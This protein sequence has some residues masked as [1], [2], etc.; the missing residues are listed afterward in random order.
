MKIYDYDGAFVCPKRFYYILSL[1]SAISLCFFIGLSFVSDFNIINC[2]VIEFKDSI[3]TSSKISKKIYYYKIDIDNIIV[4]SIC[5]PIDCNH[6]CNVE[7]KI[8]Y[9]YKCAIHPNAKNFN[10]IYQNNTYID[11]SEYYVSI[12]LMIL[13]VIIIIF[14]IAAIIYY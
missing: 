4:K 8:N 7:F 5:N 2:K 10:E 13:S 3:C 12:S 11:K 14:S 6:D 9:T 1:M